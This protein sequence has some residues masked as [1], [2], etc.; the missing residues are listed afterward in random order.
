MDVKVAFKIVFKAM[1][2]QLNSPSMRKNL[3]ENGMETQYLLLV[4]LVCLQ[5]ISGN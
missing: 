5:G 3:N 4:G 2:S 1:V